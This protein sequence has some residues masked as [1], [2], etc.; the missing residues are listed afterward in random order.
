MMPQMP[1]ALFEFDQGFFGLKV[2]N[3]RYAIECEV[4]ETAGRG[5]GEEPPPWSSGAAI[6]HPPRWP[7]LSP[8]AAINRERRGLRERNL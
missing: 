6:P 2:W 7:V 5:P 4:A 1:K 3:D 8:P